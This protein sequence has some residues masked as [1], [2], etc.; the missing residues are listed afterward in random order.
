M[1]R[2]CL[3]RYVILRHESTLEFMLHFHV[4]APNTAHNVLRYCRR[5]TVKKAGYY[6]CCH[7]LMLL[8]RAATPC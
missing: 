8:P 2:R 7:F 4:Y 5:H 1:P 6:R 3:F